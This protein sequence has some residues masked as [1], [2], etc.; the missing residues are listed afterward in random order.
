M[1]DPITVEVT[2]EESSSR[3][4]AKLAALED[5]D[6]ELCRRKLIQVGDHKFTVRTAHPGRFKATVSAKAVSR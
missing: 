3:V 1:S 2:G 5:L 6:R 4:T